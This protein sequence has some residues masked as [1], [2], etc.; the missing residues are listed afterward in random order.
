MKAVILLDDPQNTDWKYLVV[1]NYTQ[2]NFDYCM[3]DRIGDSTYAFFKTDNIDTVN[4]SNYEY[5]LVLTPGVIFEFSYW[6]SAIRSQVEKSTAKEITFDNDY[7]KVLRA[8]GTGTEHIILDRLLPVVDASTDDS[9]AMTHNSAMSTLVQNSNISYI[10]HNEIPNPIKS[11]TSLDWAM[12]VSSGFYINYVLR[13]SEFTTNTAIHHIDVSPMSLAV[14]RYTIENWDGH[15]FYDWMDHVYVKFPLLEIFN[16]KYRLHSHHP[17]A[18]KCWQHVVD[19]FGYDG[20]IAHWEQYT[21]CKHTYNHCNLMDND[22]L[23]KTFANLDMKGNGAFWWNGALKRLPANILK[24]SAQSHTGALNFMNALSDHNPETSVYGS[25]HCTNP[26]NGISVEQA[27]EE[28]SYD[29]RDL[30]WKR[31]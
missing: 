29:S 8:N 24:T 26:F 12:T 13:Q 5:A 17:A 3:A 25:D 9:F 2:L 11:H 31:C 19:T 7:I 6:E 1:K 21:A 20:W 16:G 30:L 23:Y 14:R 22:K 10:I 27:I 15:N 28:A 4:L 18:R